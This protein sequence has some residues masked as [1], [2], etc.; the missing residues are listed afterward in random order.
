MEDANRNLSVVMFAHNELFYIGPASY[1]G[2]MVAPAD[3]FIDIDDGISMMGIGSHGEDHRGYKF[4]SDLTI[5][6]FM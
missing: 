2:H 1:D 3:I 6:K 5:F 4:L